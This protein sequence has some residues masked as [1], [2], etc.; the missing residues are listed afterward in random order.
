MQSVLDEH[1]SCGVVFQSKTDFQNPNC[2]KGLDYAINTE[3]I[4]YRF[5]KTESVPLILKS[6]SPEYLSLSKSC[7]LYT[8][9][10][11]YYKMEE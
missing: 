6:L 5:L 11:Y 10:I 9:R 3:A 7:L 4:G 1:Q 2:K 8:I